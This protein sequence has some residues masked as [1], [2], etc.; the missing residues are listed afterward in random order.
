MARIV[1]LGG[2]GYAGT[3]IVTEAAQR[4]HD[5]LSVS[6][7]APAELPAGAA[8]RA[9]DLRDEALLAE[10]LEGADV[11]IAASAP[12]GELAEPGVLRGIYAT[13]ARLAGEKGARFGVVGGAGS[14]LVAEGGPQVQDTPDFPDAFKAEA[15]ELTAVLG[16][17]RA[18]ETGLDWFFVSPAGG[19][20]AYA[21]GER[22][23]EYR[24]SDDVLLVDADGNSALSAED[25]GVA[26]LD[27]IQQPSHRRARFHVAY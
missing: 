6:R 1:V 13:V 3:G 23:G 15:N 16:D 5:V 17:L 10:V 26:I 7:T 22:T 19:F 21:P 9:G 27:E 18:D 4:G 2:T 11:V 8:H 24:T 20:G 14:T 25:L 12:R